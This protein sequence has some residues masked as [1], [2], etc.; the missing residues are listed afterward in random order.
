MDPSCSAERV[1]QVEWAIIAR[2]ALDHRGAVALL[3]AAEGPTG[4]AQI[5]TRT[6]ATLTV[7]AG[8]DL[9]NAAHIGARLITRDSPEWPRQLAE[10]DHPSVN[11]TAPVAL[12]ARGAGRLDTAGDRGLAVVGARAC[13]GHGRAATFE[14]TS[15][16]AAQGWMIVTGGAYGVD[17]AAMEA[18]LGV[19]GSAIV[20]TASGL[21]HTYPTA[22][23]DLFE[24]V[25]ARGLLVSEYPPFDSP[26]RDRFL[27]RNRVIAALAGAAMVVPEAG[28]R[29]GSLNAARW[30]NSLH[31]PVFTVAT[32]APNAPAWAGCA[33]MVDDGR[34]HLV[35]DSEQLLTA[36]AAGR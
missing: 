32:A 14:L 36:L 28:I 7:R 1:R 33:A 26:T 22:N 35:T 21:G 18:T 11:S 13:T 24:K 4:T 29:S 17:T 20:V 25:T 3:L 6:T 27:H 9:S 8:A 34:A 12:W 30:A 23:K 15:A 16:V 2:A 31:R 5:L 19:E 10:L